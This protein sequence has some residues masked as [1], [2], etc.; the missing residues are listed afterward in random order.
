MWAIASRHIMRAEDGLPMYKKE[1]KRLHDKIDSLT[2]GVSYRVTGTR[3]VNSPWLDPMTNNI[4]L[5]C[6]AMKGWVVRWVVELGGRG[7]LSASLGDSILLFCACNTYP[8]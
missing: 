2:N 7:V 1:L 3:A 6:D 4:C 5:G 8:S